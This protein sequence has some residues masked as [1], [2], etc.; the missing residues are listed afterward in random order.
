M[1]SAFGRSRQKQNALRKSL[2]HLHAQSRAHNEEGK[3]IISKMLQQAKNNSGVESAANV[4]QLAR[5]YNIQ[6]RLSMSKNYL[7]VTGPIIL[8][9]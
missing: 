8:V 1:K 2:V 5:L 3:F 4:D 9:P 7:F 6:E